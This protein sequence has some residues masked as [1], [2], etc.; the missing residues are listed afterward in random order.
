MVIVMRTSDFFVCWCRRMRQFIDVPPGTKES[1]IIDRL[2]T[3]LQSTPDPVDD[4]PDTGMIDL[5]GDLREVACGSL[6][7]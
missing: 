5:L 4:L 2:M 6:A 7:M 1:E 3:L